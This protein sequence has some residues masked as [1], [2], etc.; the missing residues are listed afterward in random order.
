ML[1]RLDAIV[2]FAELDESLDNPIRTFS[3]GMQT[4]LAFSVAVGPPRTEDHILRVA[5]HWG[6]VSCSVLFGTDRFVVNKLRLAP[7]DGPW[8]KA[9]SG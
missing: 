4:R 1:E 7:N 8:R 2:D 6:Q 3:T 5:N 9:A